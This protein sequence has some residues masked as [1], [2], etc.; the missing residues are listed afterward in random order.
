MRLKPSL[1]GK[2]IPSH[3]L[4]SV[5]STSSAQSASATGAPPSASSNNPSTT[6]AHTEQNAASATDIGPVQ[7]GGAM[8]VQ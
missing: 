1:N 2:L 7:L 8:G 5:L 3:C 6:L 4:Q